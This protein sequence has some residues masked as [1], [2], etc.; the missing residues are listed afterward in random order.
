MIR[1]YSMA[2]YPEEKGI[3]KFNIRIASPPPGTSFPPGEASSY[4]FR[5]LLFIVKPRLSFVTFV[6]IRFRTIFLFHLL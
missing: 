1:A 3:M 4:L 2:N 5:S 6:G